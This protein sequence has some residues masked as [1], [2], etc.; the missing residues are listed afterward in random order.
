MKENTKAV[1]KCEWNWV[2]RKQ[3]YPILKEHKVN[4]DGK[5]L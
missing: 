1:F 5:T 2:V 4:V 3:M